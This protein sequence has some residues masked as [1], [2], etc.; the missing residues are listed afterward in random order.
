MAQHLA[1]MIGAVTIAVV[2][3]LFAAGVISD[4][5]NHRPTIRML[6]LAFL[7]LIGAVLAADGLG[8]HIDRG[9]VYFAMV[10]AVA[11]EMLNL[12]ERRSR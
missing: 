5:V 7:I 8:Q 12:R 6:A 4:F 1:V 3:M 11:V 9:Y 10:F 2:V